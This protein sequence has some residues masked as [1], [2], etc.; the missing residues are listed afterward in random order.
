MQKHKQF[1]FV[2]IFFAL[3][4][5]TFAQNIPKPAEHQL[6]KEEV[7]AVQQFAD[8]QAKLRAEYAAI[9]IELS[10]LLLSR[11]EKA[12]IVDRWQL[13]RRTDKEI[14]DAVVVWVNDLRKKYKCATCVIQG[15]KLVEPPAPAAK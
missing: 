12:S 13:A 15:D 8:L 14:S 5:P 1:L 7:A 11:D 10:K 2:T 9:D 4:L 3:L 6:S